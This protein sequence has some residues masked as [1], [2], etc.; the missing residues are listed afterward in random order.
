MIE[1]AIN[2]ELI[3]DI[4]YNFIQ[5]TTPLELCMN[6]AFVTSSP[7]NM[8]AIVNEPYDA[9]TNLQTFILQDNLSQTSGN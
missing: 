4:V 3:R 9:A 1:L 8:V 2:R 7:V 5:M 6:T